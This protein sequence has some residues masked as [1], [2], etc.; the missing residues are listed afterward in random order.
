MEIRIDLYLK[1]FNRECICFDPPIGKDDFILT[2]RI[3][4]SKLISN[5]EYINK[6]TLERKIKGYDFTMPY[7]LEI[8]NKFILMDGNHTVIAKKIRGQKYIY[9]LY[10]KK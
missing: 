6:E 9:C 5:Q 7:V 10:L 8:E 4:I 2:K 3:Q 1:G